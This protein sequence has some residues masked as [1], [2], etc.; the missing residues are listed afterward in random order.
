M[1]F[2]NWTAVLYCPL[3]AS[4]IYPLNINHEHNFWKDFCLHLIFFLWRLTLNIVSNRDLFHFRLSILSLCFIFSSIFRLLYFPFFCLFIEFHPNV[5]PNL[6]QHT[7][8]T[9]I[10][11][12]P[13]QM[14]N[15]NL[16]NEWKTNI[17]D[18]G[19]D[20]KK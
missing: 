4:S 11:R 2:S 19:W 13:I 8:L 10:H 9:S 14:L 15:I 20:G 7:T 16:M 6:Q 5:N 18:L 12:L 3:I 17:N 1:I